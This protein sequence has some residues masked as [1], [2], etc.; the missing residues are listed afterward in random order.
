MV[1]I[2]FNSYLSTNVYVLRMQPPYSKTSSYV[3]DMH[4]TYVLHLA[5]VMFS[6]PG[7]SELSRE[8]IYKL[9]HIPTGI[10]SCS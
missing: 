8:L 4:C 6:H 10:V 2:I 1:K 9:R 5:L 3:I 7:G